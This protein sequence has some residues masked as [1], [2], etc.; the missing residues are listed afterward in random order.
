MN[1]EREVTKE[2][3]EAETADIHAFVDTVDEKLK[4]LIVETKRYN[5]MIITLAEQQ[6]ALPEDQRICDHEFI[7]NMEPIVSSAVR[8]LLFIELMKDF[9]TRNQKAETLILA[10]LEQINQMT[11]GSKQASNILKT[12]HKKD[13]KF[14]F[15]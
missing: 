10:V 4:S 6:M 2:E 3:F 8:A 13:K 15:F 9:N 5:E 11:G 12:F 1:F 14:W 7:K